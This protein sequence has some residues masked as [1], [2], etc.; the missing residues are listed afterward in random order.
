MDNDATRPYP[1]IISPF[2]DFFFVCGG[3]VLFLLAL[4][5]VFLG[6]SLPQ[7]MSD[8]PASW[9]ILTIVL[10]GNH[11]FADSHNSATYFRIWGGSQDQARF[12]FH[13]TWLVYS[14]V[15]FFIMGL[16]VPS[17][18][19]IYVYLYV[20]T[21]FWHYA[22]QSFGIALIYCYK[23]NYMLSN[24]E[25]ESFRWFIYSM[26]GLIFTRNLCFKPDGPNVLFGV[27]APFW[28]PLPIELYTVARF[29]VVAMSAAL[30][31]LLVRKYFN[32]GKL[33]PWQAVMLV[34]TITFMALT[35][36]LAKGMF[37]LFVPAFFHGTQYLAVCLSYYLKERGMPQGMN[38]WDLP[39]VALGAPG[40]KYLAVV[41]LS[42][43]FFYV[44][45]PHFFMQ[46]GFDRVYV[47]GLVLACVNYHHFVTDAAIW[48]LKDKHNRSILIA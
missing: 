41:I 46:I 15:A 22:A 23:H 28:G 19:G 33:C 4:N 42:G 25:K 17:L 12:K 45:L 2:I 47:A 14:A 5:Y 44:G 27:P 26:V 18:T 40:L 43:L 29:S 31:F 37:L 3:G 20:L 9:W 34:S 24:L 16:A 7:K 21:V 32:Q 1:W 11:L 10:I 38:T 30:L 36:D 8:D 6:W 48:R 35:R 39:K 13:R